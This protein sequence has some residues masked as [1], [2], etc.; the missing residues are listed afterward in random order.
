MTEAPAL[1][2]S[3]LDGFAAKALRASAA[4]WFVVAVVGQW[5]FAAYVAG[6]FGVT[7]LRGDWEVWAKSLPHGIVAGDPMGNL[8]L[9]V[10]LALAFVI[11]VGGPLQLAPQVRARFPAFH[12][13]TGRVYMPTAFVIAASGLYMVWTR[14]VIGPLSNHLAISLN[15]VLIMVCAVLALRYALARDFA[16]HRRWAL[17]LFLVVSGVWFFR[18]GLMFWI[19]ANQGPVGV[20]EH[21][22][23]PFALTLAYAQYLLPLAVLEVYLRVKAASGTGARLATAAALLVLTAA[24]G[25]GIAGA[26]AFMWLPRF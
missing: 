17:R 9:V 8:A 16:A 20:G 6:Y 4:T 26:F 1:D 11:T 21:L 12:R 18:V 23:G 10:H 2:R 24:M 25:V 7:G 3:R 19:I 15:A 22:D 5:L 13:W 14:G